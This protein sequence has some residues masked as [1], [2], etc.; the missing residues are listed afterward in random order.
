MAEPEKNEHSEEQFDDLSLE[1]LL[2]GAREEIARVDAMMGNPADEPVQEPDA[3]D[4]LDAAGEGPADVAADGDAPARTEPKA[5]MPALAQ[6][7]TR[8]ALYSWS[9]NLSP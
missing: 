9:V 7:E 1:E 2:R 3:A 5:A 6:A 4:A 8:M